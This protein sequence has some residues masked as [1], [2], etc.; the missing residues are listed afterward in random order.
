MA[1]AHTHSIESRLKRSP[2]RDNRTENIQ[3][4]FTPAEAAKL[5]RHSEEQGM[6]MAEWVRQVLLE[7]ADKEP[8]MRALFT[9]ITALRLLLNNVL[10]P[11][12]E[13]RKITAP[14]FLRI[15]EVVAG[16]KTKVARELIEQYSNPFGGK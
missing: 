12:A 11:I 5:R 10:G 16:T 7:E 13:G 4:R 9:E 1:A 3:A 14:E 15:A 8:S 2:G 6:Y